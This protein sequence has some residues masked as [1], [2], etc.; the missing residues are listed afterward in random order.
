MVR[1]TL[2]YYL[3]FPKDQEKFILNRQEIPP[4]R[5]L[6]F[7][8]S[9][10]GVRVEMRHEVWGQRACSQDLPELWCSP[11]PVPPGFAVLTILLH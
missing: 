10:Q 7:R 6:R 2:T 4:N 5:E 3:L 11:H 1:K 8:A 9:Y